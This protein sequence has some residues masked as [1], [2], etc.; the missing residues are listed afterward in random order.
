MMKII[1][2]NCQVLFYYVEKEEITMLD[3]LI[4]ELLDEDLKEISEN[5][6]EGKLR[7]L[8]ADKDTIIMTIEKCV[9]DCKFIK[10]CEFGYSDEYNDDVLGDLYDK[11]IKALRDK[12]EKNFKEI[13][14]FLDEK[15][16]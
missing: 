11:I 1:L 3:K 2:D 16:T 12:L 5:I 14:N 8:L 13:I 6:K 10:A 9:A 15:S 4:R 7:S